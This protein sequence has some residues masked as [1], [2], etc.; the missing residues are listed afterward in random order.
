MGSHQLFFGSRCGGKTTELILTFPTS[1][2]LLAFSHRNDLIG[3]N[4]TDDTRERI[5]EINIQ[6][7][8]NIRDKDGK[9]LFDLN[10][11]DFIK[12]LETQMDKLNRLDE[13]FNSGVWINDSELIKGLPGQ[14][15][16]QVNMLAQLASVDPK[17]DSTIIFFP[18]E[19]FNE[20]L[21]DLWSLFKQCNLNIPLR[22]E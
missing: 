12:C 1:R 5:D 10:Y 18:I 4:F 16:N 15:F 13:H 11:I 7:L 8:R 19:L 17:L 9:P 3:K 22:H 2:K 21:L 6:S 14:L 20:L